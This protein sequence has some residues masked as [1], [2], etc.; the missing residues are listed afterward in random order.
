MPQT[1]LGGRGE[2]QGTLVPVGSG[3]PQNQPLTTPWEAL[4]SRGSGCGSHSLSKLL[5]H[6]PELRVP[7]AKWR[8]DGYTPEGCERPAERMES[9]ALWGSHRVLSHGHVCVHQGTHHHTTTHSG[10]VS[11]ASREAAARLCQGT[12]DPQHSCPKIRSH[13]YG[14]DDT[15]SALGLALGLFFFSFVSTLP[16][17]GEG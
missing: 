17:S 9:K 7:A 16:G 4:G 15:G 10:P 8:L 12:G 2:G 14:L 1:D 11:T 3:R 13:H 5:L 6:P